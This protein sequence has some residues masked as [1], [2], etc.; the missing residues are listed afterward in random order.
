MPAILFVCTGN[1]FRSPIAAAAFCRM[2]EKAGCAEQ[3]TVGSAGTWG[4]ADLPPLPSAVE[5]AR[6]LG[7]DI[8]GSRSRLVSG[9]ELGKYDLVVVM[10]NGHKE[11]ILHEFPQVGQRVYLLAEIATGISY[12]I[13]DPMKL[14]GDESGEI[15]NEI[16]HLI[17]K[18]FEQIR[19]LAERNATASSNHFYETDS[20]TDKRT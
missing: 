16:Y 4:T 19:Q 6:E 7:F 14:E 15:P 12:D 17:Q 9:E 3:W 8:S 18:A 20:P 5:A 2:L 1:R 11:A 13:P 10:E